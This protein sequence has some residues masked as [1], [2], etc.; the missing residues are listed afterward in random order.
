MRM[1]RMQE[2]HTGTIEENRDKA[3]DK[4]SEVGRKKEEYL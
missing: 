3:K 1:S 2:I 4:E